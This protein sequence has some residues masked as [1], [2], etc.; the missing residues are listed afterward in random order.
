MCVVR[1]ADVNMKKNRRLM[2]QFAESHFHMQIFYFFASK[3]QTI[4]P[5]NSLSPQQSTCPNSMIVKKCKHKL[6]AFVRVCKQH[7]TI[8]TYRRLCGGLKINDLVR[9]HPLSL[10]SASCNASFIYH[11]KCLRALENC[12]ISPFVLLCREDR[13]TKNN[14]NL[15]T[16]MSFLLLLPTRNTD[17]LAQLKFAS[18]SCG[19]ARKSF[20]IFNDTKTFFS[21]SLLLLKQWQ[22]PAIW[23]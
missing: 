7:S 3:Y 2:V 23:H 5:A 11:Q 8:K 21:S 10:P 9:C 15:V 6:L 1:E 20:M 16:F 18:I 14:R 17:T 4:M 19:L 12:F 13:H 22:F